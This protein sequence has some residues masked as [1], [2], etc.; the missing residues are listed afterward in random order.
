MVKTKT[1]VRGDETSALPQLKLELELELDLMDGRH[2]RSR[3]AQRSRQ[4]Q[5]SCYKDGEYTQHTI[6]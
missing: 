2:T 1:T 5:F 3:I 4:V 6:Q